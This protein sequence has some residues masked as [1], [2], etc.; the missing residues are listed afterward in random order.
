MPASPTA[1]NPSARSP[2]P[3]PGK[4]YAGKREGPPPR[5]DWRCAASARRFNRDDRPP[6]AARSVRTAPRG[7]RPQLQPR[8]PSPRRWR[9]ASELHRDA[10]AAPRSRRCPSGRAFFRP[11]VR[12]QEALHPARG[13]RREAALYAAWRPAAGRSPVQR[14]AVA[15]RRSSARRSARAK[16]RRRQE[17]LLARRTGSWSRAR[18]SAAGPIAVADRGDSKPWQKRDAS[19]PDHAGRNSR[20]PRDGARNFDK[21][22][23]ERPKFDRPRRG[24]QQRPWRPR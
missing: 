23:D 5:R 21:P 12:R 19:S 9:K 17:V 6:A 13:W 22:R 3:G 24:S 4:P 1:R 18:I 2:I 15:R 11:E 8:R 20:P 14:A 7:D 10:A 16:I